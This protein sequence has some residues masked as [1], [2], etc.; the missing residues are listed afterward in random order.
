MYQATTI[1]TNITIP[2]PIT[3][4][5]LISLDSSAILNTPF[6]DSTTI[7]NRLIVYINIFSI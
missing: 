4:I 2:I 6:V 7:G 5:L 1:T 3:V